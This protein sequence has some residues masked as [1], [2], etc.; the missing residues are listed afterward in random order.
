MSWAA[1]EE[2]KGHEREGAS[3][4]RV[5]TPIVKDY[6]GGAGLVSAPGVGASESGMQRA[7]R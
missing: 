4:R 1:C 3:Y 2:C 5:W 6:A 7:A